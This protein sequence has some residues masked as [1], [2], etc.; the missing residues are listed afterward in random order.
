MVYEI[1]EPGEPISDEQRV[2]LVEGLQQRLQQPRRT[3]M[4]DGE[5]LRC[6]AP[7]GRAFADVCERLRTVPEAMTR[8]GSQVQVL[9]GPPRKP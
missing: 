9:H 1:S 6:I 7:D 5:R 2:C 8:K 4:N 3:R